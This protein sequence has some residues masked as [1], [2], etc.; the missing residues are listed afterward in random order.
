MPAGMQAV[1]E[2]TLFSRPAAIFSIIGFADGCMGLLIFGHRGRNGNDPVLNVIIIPQSQGKGEG[3]AGRYAQ[4]ED[5][6]PLFP[7]MTKFFCN[8]LPCS[9]PGAFLI[10]FEPLLK[11]G[12]KIVLLNFP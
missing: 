1:S 5:H 11:P 8:I 9:L 3:H 2:R 12:I 7:G 6:N 4:N 10:M